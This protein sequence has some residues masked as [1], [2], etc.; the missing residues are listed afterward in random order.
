MKSVRAKMITLVTL[1]ILFSVLLLSLISVQNT[2]RVVNRNAAQLMELRCENTSLEINAL[3]SRISQSVTTLSDYLTSE[4]TDISQFRSNPEYVTAYTNKIEATVFNA[5]KN[6]EGALTAYVRFNPE[7]TAPTSGL[8]CSRSS[9]N[10]DF[11]KLVPTD[12]SSYDPSDTAH[13][14]WYYVPVQNGKPTW[15][16]PYVNENLGVNMISYVIPLTV[17]GVS[18]GIVGMDIDFSTLSNII[19]AATVYNTGYAFLSNSQ[20][21][22]LYHK[23]YPMYQNISDINSGL[24]EHL[25]STSGGTETF[26]YTY[27]NTRKQMLFAQLDNDMKLV[28][29][30]PSNEIQ[31]DANNLMRQILLVSIVVV[32]LAALVS[33]FLIQ[34]LVKPIRQL[35]A[36]AMQ[37]ADGHLEVSITC[38]SKD[39]IG[40]LAQNFSKAVL[41]LREYVDYIEEVSNVLDGMAEGNLSFTLHREYVGEFAKVKDALQ[42][43]S[44]LLG[45]T[46]SQIHEVSELVAS[47]SQQVSNGSQALSQGANE[48]AASITDLSETI[49]T[50][51]QQSEENA[52]NA[53]NAA[54]LSAEAKTDIS[55]SNDKMRRMITAM[56]EINR[57]SDEIGNIVKTIDEIARQTNILALNAAVEAAR[58][59][60]AGK[61]FAVVAD[62][63][64]SLA[65]KSTQAVSGTT[66][67][68]EQTIAAVENGTAIADDTA[69][70]LEDTVARVNSVQE[71]IEEIVSASEQQELSV[72]R[73]KQG[74]TEI[75][76]VVQTNSATA[77][78][79]AAT[80][81]ELNG[82]A[83]TLNELIGRF[84]FNG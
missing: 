72:E 56:S 5:A 20:N 76:S 64:R 4:L 79:S 28:L 25:N 35:S 22:I 66:A 44:H 52:T 71:K 63:V 69:K 26:T 30:A 29:T 49:R 70:A 2:N 1:C 40:T 3:L 50:I 77:E 6:T 60:A 36:A 38:S 82:Q 19:D 57:M 10:S 83:H 68:I 53:R 37:V 45:N 58:A 34:K 84:R 7:F 42:R 81:Q 59:G 75:S 18:I 51:S 43:V 55:E 31:A 74:V 17:N 15:M 41:R 67:L 73:V 24:A 9:A 23:D 65:Q 61:G 32:A 62:E 78:E 8:F 48:Q 21:Q 11:E 54:Q 47:G 13:V 12:F 14:G 16:A 27:Q 33:L 39:E 80:S 46:L